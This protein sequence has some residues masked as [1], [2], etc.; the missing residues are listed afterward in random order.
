MNQAPSDIKPQNYH[1][2]L[3]HPE[4]LDLAPNKNHLFDLNHLGVIKVSGERAS[5]FLQGQ[6]SCDMRLVNATTIQQGALCN[7]KGRVL[8]LL[9]V[10]Y[11]WD[12][13]WLVLPTDLIAETLLSLEKA[14]MLSRVKLEPENSLRVWGLLTHSTADILPTMPLPESPKSLTQ[15]KDCACYQ[16]DKDLFILLTLSEC[17]ALN[18]DLFKAQNQ[19]KNAQAW[20]HNQL[21]QKRF[22]IYPQT[23]GLFLPHRLNLHN[24]GYL[25]FNKGCYKGQEIIA[26][27]HYRGTI[28]H[29]LITG[30][31]QCNTPLLPGMK[32]LNIH[33]HL[34]VGELIDYCPIDENHHYRI[35]CSKLLE[36]ED[37]FQFENS[38]EPISLTMR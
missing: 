10:L 14:A 20:H 21:Q 12:T 8:T 25:S 2:S 1:T 15:S 19:L 11:C 17:D 9:D 38:E 27:T 26:R 4:A 34:E 7:L 29:A 35:I 33:T 13:Y 3:P 24:T 16:I 28:K 23:R 6:L 22:S 32:L 36:S 31:I 37:V 30:I 5:E 18:I